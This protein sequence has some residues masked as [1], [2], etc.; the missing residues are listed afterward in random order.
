MRAISSCEGNELHH[1]DCSQN[2][3]EKKQ[4][5]EANYFLLHG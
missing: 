3:H 5:Q 2:W 4:L 1:V